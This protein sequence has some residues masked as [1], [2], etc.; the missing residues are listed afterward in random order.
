[1]SAAALAAAALCAGCR[2]TTK[3][4]DVWKGTVKGPGR[5]VGVILADKYELPLW[6]YAAL[7]LVDMERGDIDGVAELGRTMERL[8]PATR[9]QIVQGLVP[10]LAALMKADQAQS[11]P[12]R[13]PPARQIRA[14]DAAFALLA[15]AKGET[16][17]QLA[18]AVVRWYTV[19]FHGRSLSGA[20]S[21]EQVV[22]EVGGSSA[23]GALVDALQAKLPQ[24]ALVK[25]AELIG[26]LGDAATK[27]RAADRLVQIEAEMR[28]P[29]FLAWL[30]QEIAV[31]YQA[32]GEKPDPARMKKTAAVNRNNF[33]QDGVLP[34]MKH[35]ADQP[36]IA[37]RLLQLA[38]TRDPALA[39]Q[40][41]R[42]L[43]AL[44]GKVREEHLD[45]LLALALDQQNPT[46]VRD[47]AFDR[48]GDIRS[49]R[50]IAPMWPLVASAPEQ[51]LR[52]R[53]GELVLAI[54]GN[55]VLEEFFGRLPAGDAA[56][57]PEE[58]EGY[59]ARMGQMTP[60]PTAAAAARLDSPNWY[61]RV[62]AL[63]FFQRKG[64]RGDLA[65]LGRLVADGTPARGKN[66]APGTTV[67][68][69]A[70]EAIAGLRERVGEAAA[71]AEKPNGR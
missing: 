36:K 51:R 14:K 70:Q 13:G 1:M 47:Y 23:A 55:A 24:Q 48:V 21:A 69:V 52:W 15:H 65:R 20:Y 8:D 12:E 3:D 37:E 61:D 62:I 5:M 58:L 4:V 63:K 50:A 59:A 71:P 43:Q 67:G 2:Y 6:T 66:W 10:G 9:A 18:D 32:S 44:E 7:A 25:L 30:E 27:E 53:A 34:A 17:R 40:R 60:L 57:E 16:R 26:Q 41:T 42:A 22:R 54:G 56:Y 31:T 64:D 19:D 29:D 35:L 68:K 33:L 11:D 39:E 46:S 38:A 28:G 49:P 45:R